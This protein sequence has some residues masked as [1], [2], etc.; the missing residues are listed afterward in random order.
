MIYPRNLEKGSK[1]GLT[2]TS[3]GF[4]AEVDLI[5]LDSGIRHFTELGYPV[6]ETADVRRDYK[7]RSSDGQTRASELMQLF[8]DPEVRVIFAASG[9]DFLVEMLSYL[10]FQVL[11]ANPKWMQGYSDTTGITFT[12]TTNLDIATVYSSNFSSFGMKTWHRSLI[13]NIKILEGEDIRQ[14]SFGQYQD[15]HKDRV[16]GL[17]EY[18]LE[19]NVEWKIILGDELQGKNVNRKDYPE[20]DYPEKGNPGEVFMSGRAL[21]G[22]LDVLL[23][24]CGTRFDKTKEFIHKYK[25]DGILWYLESFDL[26]SEALTR[27]L[28]QLKESGWFENA[29]GFLFGRPAMFRSYTDTTYEEAVLSVL[30]DFKLPIIIDADIGHKPP[31]LTMMNGAFTKVRCKDG[32]GN[33]EIERR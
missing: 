10:D 8:T 28:W 21:G 2:A 19:K 30:K 14:D 1:V 13:D 23:N 25:N 17:E 9:G 11:T 6:K 18:V 5:R 24:L 22:C 7:G 31:Q 20:K 12:I 16:T 32:K 4:T 27:G 3:A 33:I 15:G 26:S 29:S